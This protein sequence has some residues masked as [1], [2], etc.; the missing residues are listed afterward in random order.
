[1]T[2]TVR[3]QYEA[4]PYP[5]RDPKDEAKRLV[6]GSPSG[7]PEVRHH[8]FSGGYPNGTADGRTVKALVAGGGTGD[9]LILLAQTLADAGTRAEITYLDLS[10]ASRRIAEARARARGL[11]PM[12]RFVTGSLIDI[13]S[14]DPGPYDYIDCCGVLHHLPDPDLGLQALAH[15]LR[16]EGGMGIM[17]YAP[18]GRDGVYPLQ[19][20]LRTLTEGVD[21][22]ERVKVAKRVIARLPPTNGFVRNPFVGDHKQSDAGLYD[23]LLHSQ[24]RPYTVDGLYE[25]VER[26]GLAVASMVPPLAYDPDPL[27]PDAAIR[28]QMGGKSPRARAALA[29]QLSGNIKTHIAYVVRPERISGCHA[30]LQDHSLI[31]TPWMF[32]TQAV[33]QK[34]KPGAPLPITFN[35]LKHRVALP[36]LAPAILSRIDG[37][38]SLSEIATSLSGGRDTEDRARQVSQTVATLI[39]AGRMVL[40]RPKATGTP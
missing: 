24:D 16:P 39:A 4:Y 36:P 14:I 25:W 1:M 31:P 15:V 21:P 22:A 20:A 8:L 30:D 34:L 23:L 32:D 5:A 28:R 27:L 26:A 29:E 3:A 38:R 35:G 17:V 37:E 19:S 7:W 33:V 12:I 2:D 10:A 6:T 11:S 40:L 18:H 9:G 13:A